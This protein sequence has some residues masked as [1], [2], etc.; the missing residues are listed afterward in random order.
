MRYCPEQRVINYSCSYSKWLTSIQTKTAHDTSV[1]SWFPFPDFAEFTEQSLFPFF[2]W[3]NFASTS[4]SWFNHAIFFSTNYPL[5]NYEHSRRMQRAFVAI[6]VQ[7]PPVC[8]SLHP[9]KKPDETTQKKVCICLHKMTHQHGN[10]RNFPQIHTF[11]VK[12]KCQQKALL[13]G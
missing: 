3:N 4:R 8:R 9:E 7:L 1:F 11:D 10:I 5:C 6:L 12:K 13:M 2:V